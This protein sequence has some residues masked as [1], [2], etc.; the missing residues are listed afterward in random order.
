MWETDPS[1][2]W[3]AVVFDLERYKKHF[4]VALTTGARE[5]IAVSSACSP[6]RSILGGGGQIKGGIC[7]SEMSA[8]PGLPPTLRSFELSSSR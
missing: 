4:I 1:V 7:S 8:L 2:G 3:L 6:A 5:S